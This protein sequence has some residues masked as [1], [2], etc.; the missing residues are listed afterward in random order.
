MAPRMVQIGP[1]SCTV[2]LADRLSDQRELGIRGSLGHPHTDILPS[3]FIANVNWPPE[4]YL[5]A[6][7]RD[8]PQ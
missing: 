5:N 2:R 1:R 7:V 6:I 8:A 4:A 3:H